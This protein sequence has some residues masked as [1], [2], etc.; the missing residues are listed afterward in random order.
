M[1]F[2]QPFRSK[3]KGV[4]DLLNWAALVDDGVILCKDGALLSA[5]FY[6]GEDSESSTNERLN[7]VSRRVNDALTRLGTGWALWFDSVRMPVAA[8]S[9]PAASHFADP[10]THLIDEERRATALAEGEHYE[11]ENVLCVMWTP[12]I[13]ASSKLADFVYDDDNSTKDDLGSG[14]IARRAR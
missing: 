5:F 2:L 9:D 6:R 14:L 10:I 13:K 4:P 7:L 1:N 8:Y 3:A 12:P 11:T